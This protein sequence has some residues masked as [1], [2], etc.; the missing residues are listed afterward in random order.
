MTQSTDKDT[1]VVSIA[2]KKGGSGKTSVL[3]LIASAAANMGLRVHLIDADRDPRDFD[4]AW[5]AWIEKGFAPAEF[6][7]A[8]S[9]KR[10]V[11]PS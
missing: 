3:M 4:S 2:S 8:C 9:D 6:A 11:M 7:S 1:V 10:A 5:T